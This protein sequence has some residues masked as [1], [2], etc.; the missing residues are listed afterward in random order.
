MGCATTKH[1]GV[2][3]LFPTSNS[4]S[5]YMISALL[6]CVSLC[7]LCC[8]ESCDLLPLLG[9]RPA[10]LPRLFLWCF[11][12]MRFIWRG[13]QGGEV[14]YSASSSSLGSSHNLSTSQFCWDTS[15]GGLD[16]LW[17]RA[18]QPNMQKQRADA[19][20][21]DTGFVYISTSW[22]N[23]NVLYDPFGSI[24]NGETYM[25]LH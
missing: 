11:P 6:Y 13:V 2:Y 17:K 14:L 15:L 9:E 16:C 3:S 8:A 19:E 1:P 12:D 18:G 20:S 10:D 5:G 24:V 7:P 22:K 21:S 4:I 23:I 25:A